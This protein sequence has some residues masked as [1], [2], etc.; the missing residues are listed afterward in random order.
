M[1]VL[2]GRRLARELD[3]SLPVGQALHSVETG[4]EKLA[5]L[6]EKKASVPSTLSTARWYLPRGKTLY[7]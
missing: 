3:P 1:F 5:K 4:V 2:A 6:V 7:E